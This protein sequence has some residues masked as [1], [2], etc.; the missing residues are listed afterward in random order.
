M[1][2]IKKSEA[3]KRAVAAFGEWRTWTRSQHIAY[4]LIRGVPYSAMERY[5][6][7]NVDHFRITSALIALGAWPE[8]AS[9]ETPRSWWERIWGKKIAEK[10]SLRPTYEQVKAHIGEVHTLVVWARKPVREKRVRP[11]RAEVVPATAE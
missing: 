10:Q 8:P 3:F 11:Q 5:A 4:G 2:K 7:D 1:E 6:N 9:E